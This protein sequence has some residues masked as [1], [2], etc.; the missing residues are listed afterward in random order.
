MV[1]E[2]LPEHYRKP[3]KERKVPTKKRWME[4]VKEYLEINATM[5][6]EEVLKRVKQIASSQ[7]PNKSVEERKREK[8][9]EELRQKRLLEEGLNPSDWAHFGAREPKAGWNTPFTEED[10][11]IAHKRFPEGIELHVSQGA[12]MPAS[13][14]D[15]TRGREFYDIQHL[16][17]IFIRI[18]PKN[19]LEPPPPQIESP[20]K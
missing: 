1:E 10:M 16:W 14:P 19:A 13:D 2:S 8:M 5:T 9:A 3:S 4:M 15:R 20:K 11:Q 7:N 17:D 6:P 18:K 12:I